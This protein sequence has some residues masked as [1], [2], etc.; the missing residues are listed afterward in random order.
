MTIDFNLALLLTILR[1]MG[2]ENLEV[3]EDLA[4]H[5]QPYMSEIIRVLIKT[6]EYDEEVDKYFIL[7]EDFILHF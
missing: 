2:N 1:R 3:L 4:K 5:M 6:A 7:M